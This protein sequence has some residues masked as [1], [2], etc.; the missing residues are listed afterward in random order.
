M[1]SSQIKKELDTKGY[2]I[3]QNVLNPNEIF[4]AQELFYNWFDSVLI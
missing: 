4:N 3:I 2:V 1:N